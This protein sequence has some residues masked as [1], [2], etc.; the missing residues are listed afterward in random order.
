MWG[1]LFL[2]QSYVDQASQET[3]KDDP[4][5]CPAC[6]HPL[7][8]RITG[9]CHYACYMQYWKQS[10]GPRARQ[11]ITLLTKPCTQLQHPSFMWQKR[12]C[13]RLAGREALNDWLCGEET[14]E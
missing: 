6:L 14:V 11:A 12:I 2:K 9:L 7:S 4:Q 8:A 5:F 3:V 13:R 1:L 10:P